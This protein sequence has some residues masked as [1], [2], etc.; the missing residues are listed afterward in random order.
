MLRH[1]AASYAVA[2]LVELSKHESNGSTSE[3]AANVI[4]ERYGLPVSYTA[5]IL[6]QLA[7]ASLL[8]SGRGPRGG[9]ALTRSPEEV[10]LLEIF[11]AVGAVGD[12]SV[13]LASEVPSAVQSN[14]DDVLGR[15]LERANSVL[16]D[17]T[18]ADLLRG[19]EGSP[20]S[21]QT[22]DESHPVSV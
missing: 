13:P 12:S 21:G 19:S 3:V 17:A 18:L 4:A 10:T 1:K 22:V 8:R 2:A 11:Q 16:A 9:F 7:K 15:A 5:K 6:G 20:G 14:L